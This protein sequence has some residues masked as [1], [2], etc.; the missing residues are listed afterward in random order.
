MSLKQRFIFS[1]GILL[2]LM[3]SGQIVSGFTIGPTCPPCYTGITCQE[4][5]C[6]E[7]CC[8]AHDGWYSCCSFSNTCCGGNCCYKSNC[9]EC[10]ANEQCR[11]CGGRQNE[12]CCNGHCYNTTTQVCCGGIHNKDNCKECRNDQWVDKCPTN[13]E[14]I[15]DGNGVCQQCG[16]DTKKCCINGECKPRCKLKDG[17]VCGSMNSDCGCSEIEVMVCQNHLKMWSVGVDKVCSSDCGSPTNCNTCSEMIPCY[18]W[19]LCKKGA[20]STNSVCSS[21]GCESSIWPWKEC[22]TCAPRT[23]IPAQMNP[24]CQQACE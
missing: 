6:L 4:H 7:A 18:W 14:T 13:C 17:N 11:V 1:V 5:T 8:P 19:Q 3:F 21:A 23:D 16:G 12:A 9:E 10:G 20:T 2:S 22:N 15:C 24:L